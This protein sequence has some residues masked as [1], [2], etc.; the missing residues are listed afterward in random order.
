[1]LLQRAG[2]FEEFG[3]FFFEEMNGD[4]VQFNMIGDFAIGF[5]R[6]PG[7]EVLGLC[8]GIG[9]GF[10]IY[11]SWDSPLDVYDLLIKVGA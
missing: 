6:F 1:M 4:V 11:C 7:D 9:A 8:D 10:V 5:F 3:P 2:E